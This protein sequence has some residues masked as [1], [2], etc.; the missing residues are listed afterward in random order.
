VATLPD[1]SFDL[2]PWQ[3]HNRRAPQ[4]G[5]YLLVH[6]A[7]ILYERLLGRC[8]EVVIRDSNHFKFGSV[9]CLQVLTRDFELSAFCVI[10]PQPG[11][12]F[13]PVPVKRSVEVQVALVESCASIVRA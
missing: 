11:L 3:N 10:Y 4:T 7:K 8:A 9:A 6:L 1:I 13:T 2:E 5:G 12:I